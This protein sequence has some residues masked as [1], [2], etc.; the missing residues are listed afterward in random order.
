MQQ[1]WGRPVDHACDGAQKN[2][3]RFIVE[4]DDHGSGREARW[5][6]AINTAGGGGDVCGRGN[7][8]DRDSL[9]YNTRTRGE[10]LIV[11]SNEI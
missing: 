7:E 10:P 5:V 6:L 8:P 9:P 1:F 11:S 3:V 4:D 2:S